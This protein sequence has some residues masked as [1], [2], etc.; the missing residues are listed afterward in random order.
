M[1][2][3]AN[4]INRRLLD[5]CEEVCLHLLP[6]GK[7]RGIHWLVGDI[8]G[9]A[10][11]SLQITMSGS[12]AGRFLDF[13]N[14]DI[15]GGTMLWLWS[16]VKNISY[17]DAVG[18]AAEFLGVKSDDYGVHRHR[19]KLYSKP[20]HE[21]IP[22]PAPESAVMKYLVEE[23]KLD[24]AVIAKAKIGETEGSQ[25]II[26]PYADFDDEKKMWVLAH[27]KT[28][29]LARPNGKKD[30]MTTKGTKRCL[31]G[32]NLIDDNVSEIVICEGEVDAL[33]WQTLGIPA[34]SVPNGVNDFEWVD[35]DWDWLARFEKIYVSMDM[36]EPGNAAALEVC[37]RLGLHRCYIVSLPQKDAND[38][39]VKGGLGREDML[40]FLQAAKAIELD[41]IKSADAFKRDVV[42]RYET[43]PLALGYSTPWE[44]ELPWRVRPG[45]MTILSGFSGHGKSQML[46]Q[47]MISLRAQGARIMDASLEVRPALTL[48]YMTR[49]ALGKKKPTRPEVERCVDWLN[50]GLHFLDCIGTV[51]VDRLMAALEYSRKRYGTDIFIIDSL[52]KCGLS[53]EDFSGAREFA[54]RL[55]TF[56]NN[57]GAHVILVA[58]S[59]KTQNGNEYS[60][61]TK[62]DVAGSSD[63]T[64]AAFNVLICW[65]HKMKKRK[66]DEA[67]T[68]NNV[69]M[70][71]EWMAQ[72]DGKILL[73]KQRYGDG[74][75]CETSIWFHRDACQFHCGA[76]KAIPYFKLEES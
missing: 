58:H 38:C 63:I 18:Q 59:R 14:R 60:I 15:K 45:E 26:F 3:D 75:E 76:E 41:E 68:T 67:R 56:C 9:S 1:S 8:S 28:I 50:E 10:G 73:D 12:A 70:A 30:C 4:D 69:Q 23:R 7:R 44:N 17:K 64:N 39:L 32:K 51:N 55:T 47:L 25:A 35:I 13:S 74:E 6:N 34:V 54:D 20:P 31:Y 42:E 29:S 5:R 37:K 66:L 62:S 36:D 49:C 48:Y 19:P 57:T 40:K 21:P 61:P 72:P 24:P 33:S 65:R 27:K 43:D 2:I 52:F 71:A 46:N 53:G 22:A 16:K 11:E